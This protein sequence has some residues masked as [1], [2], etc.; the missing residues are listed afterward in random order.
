[1]T[2]FFL[3]THILFTNDDLFIQSFNKFF[4]QFLSFKFSYFHL[5]SA[6]T[7]LSSF[8]KSGKTMTSKNYLGKGLASK[9]RWKLDR[10]KL[11]FH[12]SVFLLIVTQ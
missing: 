3:G 10:D 9:N 5:S 6:H 7:A 11:G 1:M 12:Y 4:L 8:L 2:D